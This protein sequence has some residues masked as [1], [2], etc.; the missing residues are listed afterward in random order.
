MRGGF[1]LRYCKQGIIYGIKKTKH[2]PVSHDV[3]GRPKV[4]RWA[5]EED[6]VLTTCE[7]VGQCGL[8]YPTRIFLK[9]HARACQKKIQKYKTNCKVERRRG[10]D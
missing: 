1:H 6:L 8:V 7:F 4:L 9:A 3:E 10:S 5:L 2:T